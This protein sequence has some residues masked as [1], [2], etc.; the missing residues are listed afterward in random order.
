MELFLIPWTFFYTLEPNYRGKGIGKEATRMMMLYG[1]YY[2]AKL[3]DAWY[4]TI[5]FQ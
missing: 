3:E 4:K 1:N 2:Y 5:L